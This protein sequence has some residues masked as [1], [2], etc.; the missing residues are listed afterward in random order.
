MA[1]QRKANF[2]LLR[3]VLMSMILFWHL[4]A[5]G[6]LHLKTNPDFAVTQ[7]SLFHLLIY[8][9]RC[10]AVNGFI[11]LSGYFGIRVTRERF[12][13][14]ST[15]MLFYTMLSFGIYLMLPE[16][17]TAL[18]E[19]SWRSIKC[20]FPSTDA[21]CWFA[22]TYL[23]IMLLSPV[24]NAGAEHI[25]K[26]KFAWMHILLI[27][28][29]LSGWHYYTSSIPETN[30]FLM[31]IYLLGRYMRLH[32]IKFM[33]K[34]CVWIWLGSIAILTG[35]TAYMYQ[36]GQL[37]SELFVRESLYSNP[38]NVI[39]AMAFF[40]MFK[41]IDIGSSSVINWF[42]SGIF[43]AY[44]ITDGY[45]KLSWNETMVSIFGTNVIVLLLVAIAAV[46]VF[47]SFEHIRKACMRPADKLLLNFVN[48]LLC[49][50]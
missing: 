24:L 49:K 25:S 15:Q 21:D 22:S 1:K 13:S 26:S 10:Y 44:L 46:L 5:H 6:I 17:Q 35:H 27:G 41:R 12:L 19:L 3:I 42:A 33:E 23:L 40:Y 9:L 2:E 16:G 11:L 34:H 39:A 7:P 29:F 50:I 43:A 36:T 31:T 18:N 45:I 38:F 8:P 14:F 48:K 47:S 30:I 28:V 20:I 32:P 4:I 37:T